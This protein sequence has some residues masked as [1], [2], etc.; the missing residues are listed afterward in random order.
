MR[1]SWC[2]EVK[3]N[4]VDTFIRDPLCTYPDDD[5]VRSDRP[6]HF[7]RILIASS[8]E[9]RERHERCI[10]TFDNGHSH[11]AIKPPYSC[12]FPFLKLLSGRSFHFML[13]GPGRFSARERHRKAIPTADYFLKLQLA[14]IDE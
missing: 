1:S 13:Q 10:S 8:S 6:F 9:R 3:L 7:S 4:D 2:V 5:A 12:S 14:R 11:A